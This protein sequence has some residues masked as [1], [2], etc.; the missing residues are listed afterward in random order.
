MAPT[1]FK[2]CLT[3]EH[4]KQSL[5]VMVPV[6]FARSSAVSIRQQAQFKV[7]GLVQLLQKQKIGETNKG[8][9]SGET[10]WLY[11]VNSS[12]NGTLEDEGI[13]KQHKKLL[14]WVRKNV[15]TARVA[16]AEGEHKSTE[17]KLKVDVA[18]KRILAIEKLV[19]SMSLVMTIPG[20]DLEMMSQLMEE[21]EELKECFENMHLEA[22]TGKK[23]AKYAEERTAA[24]KV[25]FDLLLSLLTKP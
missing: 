23:A 4:V 7:F 15:T 18:T 11:E 12:V 14:K 20:D 2:H 17:N 6:A 8:F 3:T 21:M 1:L 22:A 13:A 16:L 10:T 25:L 24:F 5:S 9:S 19:L